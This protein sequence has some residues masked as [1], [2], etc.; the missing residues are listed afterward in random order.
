MWMPRGSVFDFEENEDSPET[1]EK[2]KFKLLS[3]FGWNVAGQQRAWGNTLLSSAR[4]I[5]S[6][7]KQI[8]TNL[9]NSV[10]AQPSQGRVS[11]LIFIISIFI[12]A[13]QTTPKIHTIARTIK[14]TFFVCLFILRL[15]GHLTSNEVSVDRREKFPSHFRLNGFS[16]A[17]IFRLSV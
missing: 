6:S 5:V 14:Q 4:A 1:K 16:N 8:S 2:L 3:D 17:F 9:H 7:P 13:F 10:G 11:R 15:V 12:I